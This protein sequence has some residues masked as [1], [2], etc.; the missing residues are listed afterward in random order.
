LPQV[1]SVFV[2][3]LVARLR[4]S[5]A[6]GVLTDR[7]ATGL[8]ALSAVVGFGV[9]LGAAALVWF[10]DFISDGFTTAGSLIAHRWWVL[11]AV[12]AGLVAAWGLARR[13][14]SEVEGD[15]VAET[16]AG[17]AIRSGQI[18]GRLVPVKIL[19]TALTLG[20]GGSG[21]REGPIVQIGS[22]IG[23]VVSRFFHLGEDQ[24]RSL[25][26]AGAA[27]GIGATFNAP[28]AGMLFALEVVLGSFAVRHL[29][30]VVIASVVA[31]I[32]SRSIIGPALSLQA[33]SYSLGDP[34]Q[35]GVFFLLSIVTA[36]A[37]LGLIRLIDRLDRWQKAR[38][39]GLWRPLM[40]G[41]VVAAIGL[42]EPDV[43]GTGQKFVNQLLQQSALFE[44]V[45][46]GGTAWW[47]LGLLAI[48]K[49]VATGLTATS[50]GAGGAFMPSL[51]IGSAL[52][53]SLGLLL[54]PIWSFGQL[55]PGALAVVGMATM[56]AAVARAPL[57]AIMLVFEVTG[58]RDYGL[59][60]PLMLSTTMATFL[61]DRFQPDSLYAAGLR[62]RGI[63]LV[64]RGEG[65]LL[66][67]VLV[68]D[69]MHRPHAV[70]TPDQSLTKA[71]A[72]MAEYQ[73]NGMAVVDNGK[74]VGVV[75]MSDVVR[76][77]SVEQGS[78]GTDFT[79]ERAMTPRPVTITPS[80]PVSRALERMAALGV[81]RLPVVS[82]EGDGVFVGLFRREEAV[83]AYHRALG[84]RTDR[85]LVR[86]RLDRLTDTDA[87]FYEF[88][89]APGSI[90]DGKLLSQVA[91]PKGST[92]VSVRRGL[93]VIVPTGRTTLVDGDVITAFGSPSSRIEMVAR[94]NARTD[95]DTTKGGN[96]P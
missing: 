48:A 2:K 47:A 17:L 43:L 55:K 34:R 61:A 4:R 58:A 16:I 9:G 14:A 72:D 35:L 65:D 36:A 22:S 6:V 37:G 69:V 18:R 96:R 66:D 26:A 70:A 13:L 57:T 83:Q 63:V 49:L 44:S 3:D 21:G 87:A 60:L 78:D 19:A 71:K 85:E 41:L 95:E 94:L 45:G 5:R 82:D 33:G 51:F 53:T 81:G 40:F 76:V 46:I 64:P 90:A 88:R 73:Y 93:G 29:S 11:V 52:G 32:T 84:E 56:M 15:G 28:I 1:P 20:G 39:L 54:E 86:R 59:I 89:I 24:I 79:V 38:K 7:E 31:A 25:V 92:I 67:S 12:P 77:E 80:M 10:I 91:W 42:A 68:G 8:L 23:S 75:T 27:A 62:R 30:T 74:V 50:G